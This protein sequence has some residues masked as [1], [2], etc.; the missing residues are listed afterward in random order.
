MIQLPRRRGSL[1]RFLACD[2]GRNLNTAL[3][4]R[5]ATSIGDHALVILMGKDMNDSRLSCR[6]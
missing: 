2:G 4:I 6:K 1:E 3:A 5:I